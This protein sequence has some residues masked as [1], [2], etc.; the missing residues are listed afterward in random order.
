MTVDPE[1]M[2]ALYRQLSIK[3]SPSEDSETIPMPEETIPIPEGLTPPGTPSVPTSESRPERS[4]MERA[5]R[6]IPPELR[7]VGRSIGSTGIAQEFKEAPIGTTLEFIGPGADVKVMKESSARVL[8]RLLEGDI[9]GGLADLGIAAASIPMMAIPGSLAGVQKGLRKFDFNYEVSGPAYMYPGEGRKIV[10]RDPGRLSIKARNLDEAKK[11]FNIE[12]KHTNAYNRIDK[13]WAGR[14]FT[15]Q[16]NPASPRV[17]IGRIQE[18]DTTHY[19][20]KSRKARAKK[21]DVI[22]RESELDTS[23][24]ENIQQFEEGLLFPYEFEVKQA[25]LLKQLKEVRKLTKDE[26]A[27]LEKF[28]TE[29]R[30]KGGSIV[31]RNPNTYNMRAI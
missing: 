6:Y 11:L 12:K 16:G 30:F 7:E 5:G 3:T 26:E 28:S 17:T 2:G 23:L 4:M 20:S 13:E 18:G 10:D 15:P 24:R 1:I 8:P 31:E 21:H 19:L 25:N 9:T 14:W 22:I 27:I 29:I